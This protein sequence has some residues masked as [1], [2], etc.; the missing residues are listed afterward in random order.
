[1]KKLAKIKG[2]PKITPQTVERIKLMNRP[3][4]R[5][6]FP[7]ISF[8]VAVTGLLLVLVLF[9]VI[10]YRAYNA[11]KTRLQMQNPTFRFKE[12]M[13]SPENVEAIATLLQQ[14]ATNSPNGPIVL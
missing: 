10:A 8:M 6:P 7:L 13:K 5:K 3:F 9:G 11:R 14:R 4:Y 1:M 12:L 2:L